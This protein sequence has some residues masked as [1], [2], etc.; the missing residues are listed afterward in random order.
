MISPTTA[1]ST[2]GARHHDAA[3][4]RGVAI[5]RDDE[6]LS[7]VQREAQAAI[8]AAG[9]SGDIVRLD[10]HHNPIRLVGDL[11]LHGRIVEDP[12]TELAGHRFRVWALDVAA[13][14]DHEFWSD[15]DVAR[16]EVGRSSRTA[17][18]CARSTRC[19]ARSPSTTR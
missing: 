19:I 7:Y 3:F 8:T 10:T 4:A 6:Y 13:L 15:E 2:T 18:T 9:L 17:S 16:F 12:E 1:V 14:A 11:R 5:S